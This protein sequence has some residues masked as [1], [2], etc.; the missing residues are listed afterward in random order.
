MSC[1]LTLLECMYYEPDCNETSFNSSYTQ[2]DLES[3]N[4]TLWDDIY[5]LKQENAVSD[6]DDYVCS[7]YT[8]TDDGDDESDDSSDSGGTSDATMLTMSFF[9]VNFAFFG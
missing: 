9:A 1:C 8:T 2:R 4:I 3:I 7:S 6:I 5:T